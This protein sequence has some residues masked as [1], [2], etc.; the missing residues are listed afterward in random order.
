MTLTAGATDAASGMVA[1]G[2][3]APFTAIRIDGGA[4]VDAAGDEVTATV[5]A[6]GVHT[7][8]YYARDAAGNVDDGA[9]S[10]GRPNPRP[11]RRRCGST[12]SPR[13]S[14]SPAPRTRAIRS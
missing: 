11:R 8:A 12:A 10:N 2:G 9:D 14:P 1:S 3:G 6:S 13:A 5:I 4:P 7:V